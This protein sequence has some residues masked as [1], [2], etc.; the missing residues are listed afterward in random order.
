MNKEE[1]EKII[2]ETIE[3]ANEEIKKNRIKNIKRTGIILGAG[4]LII[5]FYLLVFK[6]EFAIQYSDGMVEV[7]VPEDKG[8]DI[9]INLKNYAST[10]AILVKTSDDTYDLY[11]NVAQTLATKMFEDK[12][13]SGKILRAG[14]GIIVDFKS[15]KLREYIPNGNTPESIMHVYY[16]DNLS[17]KIATLTDEEL[18]SYENKVLIWERN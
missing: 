18:I 1:A 14:N 12:D 6:C 3:Y 8:L 13:E 4:I 2:K 17:S 16:I 11:I 7:D 15:E 10:R 9:K 5:L